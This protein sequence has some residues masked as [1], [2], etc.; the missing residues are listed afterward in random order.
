MKLLPATNVLATNADNARPN[1][2]KNVSRYF[3][4]NL[5]KIR[6]V[7]DAMRLRV[8]SSWNAPFAKNICAMGVIVIASIRVNCVGSYSV[9]NAEM[10]VLW[11]ASVE[12]LYVVKSVNRRKN[13]IFVGNGNA[14]NVTI[15]KAI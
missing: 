10:A 2:A 9:I 8:W 15:W 7:K 6:A 14:W 4:V 13:A 12:R 5:A 3:I 1:F 11:T